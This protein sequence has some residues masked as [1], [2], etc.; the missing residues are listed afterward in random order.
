MESPVKRPQ[1]PGRHPFRTAWTFT[2]NWARKLLHARTDEHQ[3]ALGFAIGAFIGVFPTFGLGFFVIAAMAVV[4][5]FNVPAA[6]IGTAVAN[7]FLGP[8]WMFLSYQV[9]K[10]V[11][12]AIPG[13]EDALV[14]QSGLFTVFLDKGTDYLIGNTLVS[15]AAAVVGYIVVRNAVTYARARMAARRAYHR[16]RMKQMQSTGATHGTDDIHGTRG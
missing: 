5:R 12:S 4:I 16:E 13:D 1:K 2:R 6:V 11:M 7:P 3:I 8:F 15:A 14:K 10:A 9:G